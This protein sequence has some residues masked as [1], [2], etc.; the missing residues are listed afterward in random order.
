MLRTNF[1]ISFITLYKQ[2]NSLCISMTGKIILYTDP[3]TK[4]FER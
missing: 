2:E 4:I 1:F 3:L